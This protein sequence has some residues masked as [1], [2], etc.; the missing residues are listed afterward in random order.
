[1]FRV[2]ETKQD[3]Y[4][5]A[6]GTGYVDN[7]EAN[8]PRAPS[9]KDTDNPWSP[10]RIP[11]DQYQS[12]MECAP[13]D[14]PEMA[15]DERESDWTLFQQKLDEAGLDEREWCV[16]NCIVFGGMSLAQT[17][18]I[19]AQQDSKGETYGKMVVSRLRDR[20]LKKLRERFTQDDD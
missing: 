16:I 3:R 5:V 18:T 7:G 4:E 8:G 17:A 6:S 9:L 12:L 1:M 15:A 20:G 13:G 2:Y 10:H 14:W 11:D 19:L